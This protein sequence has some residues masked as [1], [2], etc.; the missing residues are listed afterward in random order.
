MHQTRGCGPLPHIFVGDVAPMNVA[1]YIH[2]C[3]I[4]NEYNLNS[5]VLT[6]T[7]G[8]VHRRYVRRYIYWLTD[9]FI[10]YRCNSYVRQFKPTNEPMFPIVRDILSYIKEYPIEDTN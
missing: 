1:P 10:L 6:N 4:I 2:R 5:S 7:L 3:H 9:K 8:Y